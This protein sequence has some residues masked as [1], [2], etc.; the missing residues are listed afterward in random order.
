MRIRL[1]FVVMTAVVV[2]ALP[3]FAGTITATDGQV[4]WQS[5]ECTA[6]AEPQSLI[7]ANPETKANNMNAHIAEY[8]EFVQAAQAYM[9]CVSQESQ[10]DANA[11]SQ[12]I[13]SAGQAVI[14]DEQRQVASLGAP[15]Q[16]HSTETPAN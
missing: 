11:A 7:P 9:N 6:P 15:L 16:T 8:N 14:E 12:A 5:T 4:S 1:A 3:S 13:V 10:R 2:S